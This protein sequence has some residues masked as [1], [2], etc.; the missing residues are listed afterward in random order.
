[1]AFVYAFEGVT[2][3]VDHSAFV[4]DT[5]VLIGDVIVGPDVYLGPS[6]V[7][8]GDMGRIV[9][10]RGANIQ[11]NCTVHCYPGIDTVVE[12]RGSIGHGAV[13]H[14][15]R[16]GRGALVGMNAV[17]MDEAVIGEDSIVAA[18]AFVKSGMQVPPA[19]LVAGLPAKIVRQ[20][21]EA[22]IAWKDEGTN[23]Y[24]DMRDRCADGLVRCEPLAKPEADRARIQ[25]YEV[26]PL[27]R[28]KA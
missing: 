9:V 18:M 11:D 13:L 25:A 19:T 22:E 7:L 26:G 14:G 21:G 12:E 15:C 20:L 1:M 2:P 10:E 28:T 27:H 16:V 23:S 6:A 4:H 24:A 5:A 8:R 3:V 17:V